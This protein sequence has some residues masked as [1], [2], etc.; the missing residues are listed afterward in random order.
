MCHIPSCH[1]AMNSKNSHIHLKKVGTQRVFDG[2]PQAIRN[3]SAFLRVSNKH[4][5]R[6][7]DGR[8]NTSNISFL[9]VNPPRDTAISFSFRKRYRMYSCTVQNT[10]PLFYFSK[11]AWSGRGGEGVELNTDAGT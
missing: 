6:F 7:L 8:M 2:F 1:Q 4:Q 5:R 10:E 9:F 3:K 11:G